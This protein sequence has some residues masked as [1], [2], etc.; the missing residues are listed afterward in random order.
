MAFG[1]SG[2]TDLAN[3][4]PEIW[5]PNMYDELR[6]QLLIANVFSRAYE[7]SIRAMGDI[8]R[9]NQIAAPTGEILT[10]DKDLFNAEVMVVNQ[11]SVTVNKRAVAA[12]EITDTAMLQSQEFE[13]EA[14]RSLIYAVRRQIEED[15]INALVPSAAAPDHQIAPASASDLAAADVAALRTLLSQAKVP[16]TNRYLFL[17]PQYFGDLLTKNTFTSSDFIPQGSPV[18]S[19]QFASPLYG[20]QIAESD[21]LGADV[22]FAVHPSALQMVM[23]QEL[24]VKVSDQHVNKKFSMLVSV[25][26]L[27]GISLFDN[28]RIAKISG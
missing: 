27:Y 21:I 17:D 4:I 2:V 1:V 5:A 10:N 3:L 28:K 6:N 14:Q 26:I 23:Q 9:V 20:F 11:N 13:Q 16:V 19:G 22:G 15:V 18:S 7:G 24:R 12:F 25:D 8:V